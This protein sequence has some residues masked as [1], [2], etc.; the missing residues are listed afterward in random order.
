[1]TSSLGA[2]YLPPDAIDSAALKRVLVIILRHHGDVLLT[3]P[4]FEVLAN[5]APGVEIDALVYDDTQPLLRFNPRL[6]QMHVIDRD[7]K[8]HGP[9]RQLFG[10]FRLLSGLMARRYDLVIHL[11]NH[12]RGAYLARLLRPRWSVAPMLRN[13]P[14]FWRGSFTHLFPGPASAG[15]GNPLLR[16]HKVE[17]NLDA[18]RRLGMVIRHAPALRLV[19]GSDGD[20]AAAEFLAQNGIDGRYIVMQP[21]SRWMF[22]CWPIEQNAQLLEALLARGETVILGCAPDAREQAML[23]AIVARLGDHPPNLKLANRDATLNR[24]AALIG[25]A[26]LFVGIDSAP[27]HIAAA[28]GTPTVALFGPSGE[29]NWGPWPGDGPLRYRVVTSAQFACRPCGQDGCGGGKVSD[30]LVQLPVARVLAAIDDV[31]SESGPLVDC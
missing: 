17:Q 27:M 1:M 23:D 21:T 4:L 22:K 19:A 16:R 6:A 31:L 9:I 3:S 30:C 28:M 24:L 26:R 15:S 5:E 25:A 8:R 20:R 2:L 11:S 29:S 18:L 12:R 7:W 13:A 10:E 14:R